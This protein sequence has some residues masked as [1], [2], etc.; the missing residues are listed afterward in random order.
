MEWGVPVQDDRKMFEFLLLESFQAG[1]SWLT[2][3]KKR[4]NF[5]EAFMEFDPEKVSAFGEGD[6]QRLLLDRGII[7]NRQKI[8]AAI[9]NARA[10]LALREK[11]EKF[12]SW[13]WGFVDGKPLKNSWKSEEEIPAETALSRKISK[14]LRSRGFSFVGPVVVYSHM[15]AT[16]MVNDHLVD[17]FRY[18][19]LSP[20]SSRSSSKERSS[21]PAMDSM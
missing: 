21:T 9:S 16:G 7:R 6:I 19:E 15:Q 12:A 20:C 1:L 10:F 11:E 14:E 18:E 8:S 17:C 13:L 3:L 2:V 4:D 5:R